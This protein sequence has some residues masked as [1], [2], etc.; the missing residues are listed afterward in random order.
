MTWTSPATWAAGAVLTAAQLNQQVR[1][2][3]LA[4]TTYGSY[5]PT[6]TAA[7][8]NP[9]I[10]NGS[11]SGGYTLAGDLCHFWAQVTPGSTTSFGTGAWSL[12]LP[13]TASSHRWAFHGVAR[14]ASASASYPIVGEWQT[15]TTIV[16][17]SLPTTAGNP[18]NGATSAIPFAWANGDD[19]FVSGTY[20][21]A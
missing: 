2:N 6:W 13:E 21:I 12:T 7:T 4:L 16:I 17:R 15:G 20:Q 10:G 19:L 14:D 8:L 1:D 9:V 18:F 11:L 3:L 5:T